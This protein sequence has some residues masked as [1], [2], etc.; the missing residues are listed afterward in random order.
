VAEFY[1]VMKG[2]GTGTVGAGRGGTETA[3]IKE[4]DAVPIQ[5]SDVHSF[6]NTGTDPLEFLIVGI[7]RDLTKHVDTVEVGTARSRRGGNF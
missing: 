7:A 1:Y 4:G 2:S 5:L 3:L 6:E